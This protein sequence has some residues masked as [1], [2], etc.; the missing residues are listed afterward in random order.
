MHRRQVILGTGVALST[1]IAGC[2]GDEG[3]EDDEDPPD[4]GDDTETAA[5]DDDEAETDDDTGDDE[6]ETGDDTGDDDGED[7]PDDEDEVDYFDEDREPPVQGLRVTDLE[8][9]DDDYSTTV[10][11]LVVNESGEALTSVEVAVA[12]YD[13]DGERVDEDTTRIGDMDDEEEV[14]F[15][16]MSLED[17]VVDYDVAIIDGA[18]AE[19]T[20]G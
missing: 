4:E 3:D 2:A 8:L 18:P 5:T 12:F 15:E 14:P 11:G 1:I 19:Q 20:P 10:S 17:D 16:V 13:A 6:A 7:E 9:E